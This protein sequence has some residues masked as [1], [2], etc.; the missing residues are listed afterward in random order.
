MWKAF[1][2]TACALAARPE[3]EDEVVA[4][5]LDTFAAFERW[6]RTERRA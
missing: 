1:G 3:Q 6:L 5:A 2:E 4:G